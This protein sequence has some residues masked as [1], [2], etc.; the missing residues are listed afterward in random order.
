MC[1]GVTKSNKTAL[2]FVSMSASYCQ[3]TSSLSY[4]RYFATLSGSPVPVYYLFAL[5]TRR[6]NQFEVSYQLLSSSLPSTLQAPWIHRTNFHNSEVLL[7][8]CAIL[9]QISALVQP[10]QYTSM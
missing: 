4:S 5:Y 3:Q 1:Q 6:E 10:I 7:S 8:P 2:C 9:K